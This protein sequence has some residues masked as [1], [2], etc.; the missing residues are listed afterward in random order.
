[1]IIKNNKNISNSDELPHLEVRE[2]LN[3]TTPII[4]AALAVDA[5]LHHMKQRPDLTN[6]KH[7][8]HDN[9]FQTTAK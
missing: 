4:N 9:D 7:N 2:I 6:T 1:M 3:N 8:T 5:S